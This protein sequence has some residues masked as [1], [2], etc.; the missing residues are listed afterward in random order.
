MDLRNILSI[1]GK[2]GLYKLLSSAQ[3]R[4][5]VESLID[6][7]KMP[8]SSVSKISSLEDISVF[9]F[10]DDI[11]LGDIFRKIFEIEEGKEAID[12]KSSEADLR[13]YMSKILPDYD[14]DR[15]YASDLKKM[16]Q[17]YN[18]LLKNG[19]IDMEVEESEESS[20]EVIDEKKD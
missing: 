1:S 18:L 12:H 7:K 14:E 2:P 11:P 4:I 8:V 15:V 3:S 13:A 17:W 16:F 19:M 20:E 6:G 5:I 10:S 9:T